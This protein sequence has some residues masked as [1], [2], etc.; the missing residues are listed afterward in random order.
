MVSKGRFYLYQSSTFRSCLCS[1]ALPITILPHLFCHLGLLPLKYLC[2]DWPRHSCKTTEPFPEVL[3]YL[4]LLLPRINCVFKGPESVVNCVSQESRFR[5]TFPT[6]QHF[7]V[8]EIFYCCSNANWI[9][10]CILHL[11]YRVLHSSWLSCKLFD[12]QISRYNLYSW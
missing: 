4:S 10:F 2:L 9:T 3:W 8:P 1:C 6:W 5:H 7:R 12:Y 11:S